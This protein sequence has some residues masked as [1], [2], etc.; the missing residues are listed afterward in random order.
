VVNEINR[1]QDTM[2]PSMNAQLVWHVWR[3]IMREPALHEALFTAG[4]QA[5]AGS[6]AG[7]GLSEEALG[8]ALAYARH[9]DRARWFVTNYRF[10]LTNSFLNALETGA[11]LTLRGLLALDCDIQALARRFLDRCEWKD[12]GPYVHAY[13]R[14]ALSFLRQALDKAHLARLG[15]LIAFEQRSVDWLM[16]ISERSAAG[17]AGAAGTFRSTVEER[18]PGQIARTPFACHHRTGAKLSTWLRDKALLGKVPLEPGVE[19]YIIYLKDA[20][21]AVRF[22]RV[23]ARA[24]LIYDALDEPRTREAI[25]EALQRRGAAPWVDHDDEC[26]ALLERCNALRMNSAAVA[27]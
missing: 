7:F 6:L 4:S 22:A 19:D 23:P 17:A 15:E 18:R 12:Y 16:G 8:A 3:R 26:L 5:N 20:E 25:S 13:C 2:T 9:A 10:R 24:A 14:D 11:P 1:L 27:S 21:S